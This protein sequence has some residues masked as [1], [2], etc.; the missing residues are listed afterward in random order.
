MSEKYSL[1][2]EKGTDIFNIDALITLFSLCDWVKENTIQAYDVRLYY[3]LINTK[4]GY[5]MPITA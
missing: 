4:K 1:K 3:S 2:I 5:S